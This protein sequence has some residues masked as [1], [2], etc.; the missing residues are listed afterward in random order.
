MFKRFFLFGLLFSALFFAEHYFS[1]PQKILASTPNSISGNLWIDTNHDGQQQDGENTYGCSGTQTKPQLALYKYANSSTPL[2][3]ITLE[4]SEYLFSN[5]AANKY[6]L[7]ISQM[8]V[9]N[10]VQYQVTKWR[11]TTAPSAGSLTDVSAYS[12]TNG[13]LADAT[14][15]WTTTPF[16]SLQVFS[17][18]E[19]SVYL[20]I[21]PKPSPNYWRGA[22]APKQSGGT[23]MLTNLN[24]VSWFFNW[25]PSG[26]WEDSR[27][28]PLVF[29]ENIDSQA[30]LDQLANQAS[31]YPGRTWLVFNEPD[32]T[33]QDNLS[34]TQG[35]QLY[36]QLYD[37][38]KG[39]DATAKLFCCGTAFS[40]TAWLEEF[41]QNLTRPVDGIHFHGYPC[42]RSVSQECIGGPNYYSFNERFNMT[43]MKQ[44]LNS[45]Y[46][47]LQSKTEFAGKPVWLSE[48]GVLSIAAYDSQTKVRDKVMNPL[49]NYLQKGGGWQKFARVAWFSTRYALYDAS[50]LTKSD[51]SLTILGTRW[52]TSPNP[53]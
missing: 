28:V 25:S 46:S 2:R 34:P 24:N 16:W 45:F 1:P 9:C 41:R 8:P 33:D 12:S 40:N 21:K 36:Q 20:G 19:T 50:N 13:T 11:I 38:V 35:A 47:Y 49:L 43:L 51:N 37:T 18:Q 26:P 22:G 5:L 10:G 53:Y 44:K 4:N 23:E 17:G 3:T 30:E 6:H 27:Y 42:S 14:D 15:T 31:Q 52:N 32:I 48:I 29:S 7:K 39:A